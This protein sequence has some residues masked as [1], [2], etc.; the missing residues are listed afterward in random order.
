MLSDGE[1]LSRYV[2]EGSE[3][4]FTE[5]VQRHINI[6][7]LAALRRVGRNAHAADDVTQKVFA[8]LARKARSLTNRP[9]LIGWLYTSTRFAAADVVRA[10]QRRRTHEQEAQIM[11]E[12][13]E[14][15]P[16]VT[17][18]LEPLLDEM[19]DL[20]PERDREAILLHFFEGRPFHEVGATLSLSADATRMRVNRALERLRT[21]LAHRGITSSATA[22]AGLLTIQSTLAAPSP[23]ALTVAGQAIS[24]AG[25]PGAGTS[26]AGRLI[27]A[28]RFS[29]FAPWAGAVLVV[30]VGG[31]AIYRFHTAEVL[32][33]PTVLI[34]NRNG[35]PPSAELARPVTPVIAE[36]VSPPPE[37]RLPAAPPATNSPSR[38][39]GFGKLSKAEQNLLAHLWFQHEAIQAPPG[40]RVGLKVGAEA[41]NAEG[42]DPLLA[43]GWI[44]RGAQPG[45]VHLTKPGLAF[46]E[47]HR[48]EIQS[49]PI[50]WGP[51]K[52]KP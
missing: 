43:K 47:A 14:D 41:P 15:K 5:L 16:V 1:L 32:S 19:M 36:R 2:E 20:L 30:V 12:L 11:N 33:P 10:E 6:V 23:L 39:S 18:Q 24:H 42:I 38:V 25:I 7:Y 31:W 51:P 27:D 3:A 37:T 49:L 48:E 28:A 8:S 34:E 4:A 26:L 29:R 21:A 35:Q 45:G 50:I 9:S 44:A 13:N 22:L 52:P 40:A 46:C 17:D